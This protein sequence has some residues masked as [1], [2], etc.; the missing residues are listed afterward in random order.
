MYRPCSHSGESVLHPDSGAV[1]GDVPLAYSTST[2]SMAASAMLLPMGI[3]LSW[4]DEVVSTATRC[5]SVMGVF[6]MHEMD[7]SAMSILTC[8]Q[9]LWLSEVAV[10][11]R[12]ESDPDMP[13]EMLPT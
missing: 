6:A 5:P 9:P 4:P 3:A 11:Y 2:V 7:E 10:P 13:P 12:M 1:E 8:T